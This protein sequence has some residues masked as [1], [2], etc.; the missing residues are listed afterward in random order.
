MN[1]RM[2]C[3][4]VG[5]TVIG[6]AIGESVPAQTM[7]VPDSQAEITLGFVPVV[8]QTA[9]AVVSI[10]TRKVVERRSSPFAGDPFFE[11]LFGDFFPG[12]QTR[13]R[14]ENS[15]GSGV[16]VD[17]SGIVVS[18]YHVVGGADAVVIATGEGWRGTLGALLGNWVGR[19]RYCPNQR[20]KNSTRLRRR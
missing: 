11:Q 14:I 18:N 19:L 4:L 1:A 16:I 9:P 10:Y 7:K 2:I 5:L 8:R 17:P 3:M 20:W 13:R 6:L 12:R 15:L